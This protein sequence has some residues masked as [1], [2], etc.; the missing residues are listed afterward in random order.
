MQTFKVNKNSWH[1]K[2]LATHAAFDMPKDFCT[3]WRLVAFVSAFLGLLI[4]L[5]LGAVSGLVYILGYF[6]YIAIVAPIEAAKTM[7]LLLAA[8]VIFSL[9]R[10]FK[11]FS[12]PRST[13]TTEKQPSLLMA[14]Y[15]SW[16]HK[17]CPAIEYI[18]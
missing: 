17:Y 13:K 15:H 1:Y 16:K 14:K 7:A 8:A 9:T 6:V 11:L 3:Y 18:E 2:M 10:L 5:G 4:I 12:K